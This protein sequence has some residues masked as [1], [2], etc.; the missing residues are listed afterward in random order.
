TKIKAAG[1]KTETHIIPTGTDISRG[2][3]SRHSVAED[4][5]W[6][7]PVQLG[8]VRVGPDLANVGLRYD[9]NWELIHLYSP[10][11]TVIGSIMPSFRYLFVTQKIGDAPSPDALPLKD[12]AAGY[13]V[14]P[15]DDAKN[16][17]AYLL[18]LRANVPLHDAPFSTAPPPAEKKK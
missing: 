1:G 11:S 9:A 6:D 7:S 2:W 12:V 10:K 16:L 3:G 13:E 14:V 17:V 5:L 8:S 18:S 15:T 4:F